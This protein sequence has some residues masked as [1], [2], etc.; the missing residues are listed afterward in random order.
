MVMIIFLPPIFNENHEEISIIPSITLDSKSYTPN[1]VINRVYKS[2]YIII[3]EIEQ[4]Y[5]IP[6]LSCISSQ[7]D[8]TD[9]KTL[10]KELRY[11]AISDLFQVQAYP[12][13][14]VNVFCVVLGMNF[15]EE[16]P[17]C[18]TLQ[19]F[20]FD[21]KSSITVKLWRGLAN[22][23]NSISI[24]ARL[25][26]RNLLLKDFILHSSSTTEIYLLAHGGSKSSNYKSITVNLS[27]RSNNLN[28]KEVEILI[29]LNHQSLLI[30][31]KQLLHETNNIISTLKLTSP[32][33]LEYK[34][35]KWTIQ[36]TLS[37]PSS[38]SPSS[39]SSSND[40]NSYSFVIINFS[41]FDAKIWQLLNENFIENF[42]NNFEI[43][44]YKL[45]FKS[46]FNYEFLID[47]NLSF[48]ISTDY[49]NPKNNNNNNSLFGNYKKLDWNDLIS[50]K[51]ILFGSFELEGILDQ[52]QKE[53]VSVENSSI[54]NLS[55]LPNEIESLIESPKFILRNPINHDQFIYI[56]NT[57]EFTDI[58]TRIF[59]VQIKTILN[60]GNFNEIIRKM[61]FILND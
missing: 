17:K 38:S 11:E 36:G 5:S 54:D 18:T 19:L 41:Y 27:A 44:F 31:S 33:Y 22:W 43:L 25:Q 23:Y 50:S 39:S 49:D 29:F 6:T 58:N 1:T 7:K 21:I 61:I 15:K 30:S 2:K 9:I 60:D 51:V 55:I 48:K 56:E 57:L 35:D 8:S 37:S 28:E 32:L 52:N 20:D 26:I 59:K 10:Y 53:V 24:G 34:N 13:N 40:Q 12:F 45:K 47:S 46:S 14:F 42:K 16:D 3:Y 4:V